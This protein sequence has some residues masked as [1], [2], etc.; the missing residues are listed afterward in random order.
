VARGTAILGALSAKRPGRAAG[1]SLSDREGALIPR[2]GVIET[3]A[4]VGEAGHSGDGGDCASA[5][6]NGPSGCALDGAGSFFI[7]D[8]QNNCVRVLDLVGWTIEAFAGTGEAGYSGD[9]GPAAEATFSRPTGVA[10]GRDGDVFICDRGN[11]AVRRVSAADGVVTTVAGTGEAGYGGDGGPGTESRLAG[12]SG[13]ALDGRGGLVICEAEGHRVRR[14]DLE[15]GV[16]STVAGTGEAG[17]AEDGSEA[18]GAQLS[19]PSGVAVDGEGNVYVAEAG[20][21]R[22]VRIGEDGVLRVV[23]GTG[24]AGASGDGGPAA[25]ATYRGP[26][27][28]SCDS[29]GDLCVADTE[30][31]AVRMIVASTGTVLRVAGGRRGFSGDGGDAAAASLSRPQGCVVDEDGVVYVADTENHRLR[32]VQSYETAVGDLDSEGDDMELDEFS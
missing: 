2:S 18:V 15:S 20:A 23:S 25:D 9:G 27:G 5:R 17:V 22:I 14:L 19:A 8:T 24:E 16:I 11:H 12:P 13:A 3:L 32:V 30:N 29:R 31:H 28:L 4:G 26:T 10:A 6:L 1:A 7:A 21:N